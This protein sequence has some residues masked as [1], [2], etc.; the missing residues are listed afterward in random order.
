MI[1]PSL[2]GRNPMRL[3][4]LLSAAPRALLLLAGL[5]SG[6]QAAAAQHGTLPVGT[7]AGGV[8]TGAMIEPHLPAPG[9]HRLNRTEYTNAIRD[10][11]ALNVD[12]TSFC[13]PTIPA[14]ASTTWPGR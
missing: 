3:K 9:L 12:A 5:A 13:R 6:V 4:T 8:D 14:T 7:R 10:L 11:L 1:S 2:K